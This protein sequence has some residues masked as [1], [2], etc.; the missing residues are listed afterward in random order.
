MDLPLL[1]TKNPSKLW[2]PEVFIQRKSSK[3]TTNLSQTLKRRASCKQGMRCA[4][5]LMGRNKS[6]KSLQ[7]INSGGQPLTYRPGDCREAVLRKEGSVLSVTDFRSSQNGLH[8]FRFRIDVCDD[9]FSGSRRNC[10]RSCTS[11]YLNFWQGILIFCSCCDTQYPV[12]EI[13]PD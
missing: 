12:G 11:G 7:F 6:H 2:L 9:C 10:K 3:K 8:F 1:Q 5:G 4:Q 13:K